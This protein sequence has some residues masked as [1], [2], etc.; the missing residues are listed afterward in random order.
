LNRHL[1]MAPTGGAF[2]LW[3]VGANVIRDVESPF[4][5]G[6]HRVVLLGG[7]VGANGYSRC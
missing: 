6:S 1:P 4:A 7:F 3:F 2:G 5:N